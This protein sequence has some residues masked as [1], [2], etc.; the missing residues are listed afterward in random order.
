MK[1][2]LPILKPIEKLAADSN[3]LLSSV[4]GKAALKIFTRTRIEVATTEFNYL[5]VLEYI[6]VVA[7]KY[8]LEAAI[9]EAQLKLLPLKK[10]P[11]EF[12][13]HE[14]DEAYKRIGKRDPDDVHLLALALKL[15]VPVWS[16]DDDYKG[17]GIQIFTTAEILKRC[18]PFE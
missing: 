7:G 12:Y 16:N 18:L 13:R 5:E 14:W 9:L 10:I 15:R 8:G 11:Q 3:V 6:P 4:A 1:N 17:C 2:Y